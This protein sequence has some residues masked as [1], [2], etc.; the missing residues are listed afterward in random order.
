MS[1]DDLLRIQDVE[2][3][4][5]P[6]R[7]LVKKPIMMG[8]PHIITAVRYQNYDERGE[9]RGYVSVEAV[10]A[11][12][13]VL[14]DSIPRINKLVGNENVK[15]ISDLFVKPNEEIVYNDSSTGIRRTLTEM[16]QSAGI[17]D[18]GGE[19]NDKR[20]F[21]RGWKDWL[22]YDQ[23]ETVGSGANERQEPY[24]THR[25]DGKPLVILALRGLYVSVYDRFGAQSETWYLS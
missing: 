8:I 16:F 10:V 25:A 9:E 11:N 14:A 12:E 7:T 13:Q 19:E 3:W 4:V 24:I 22:R 1:F 20:R 18:V 17:I 15:S 6:G 2:P 23:F 5:V 21:D